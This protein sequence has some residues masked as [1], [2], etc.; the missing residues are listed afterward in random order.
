MNVQVSFLQFV[1][2]VTVLLVSLT[3]TLLL[4]S[5]SR[6]KTIFTFVRGS[7]I[8]TH[9]TVDI[10]PFAVGTQGYALLLCLA[11]PTTSVHDVEK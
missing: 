2:V 1:H 3:P 6:A 11:A 8:S 7:M 4:L 5:L 9:S 10:L